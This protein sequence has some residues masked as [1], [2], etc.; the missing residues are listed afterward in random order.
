MFVTV[1]VTMRATKWLR[2]GIFWSCW[3]V[4]KASIAVGIRAT[5]RIPYGICKAGNRGV[6]RGLTR[7][8][9]RF[10]RGSK[11]CISGVSASARAGTHLS[12]VIRGVYV[13]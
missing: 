5:T 7:V 11:A 8:L 1:R 10:C 13:A 6:L 9:A 3:R 12:C 2:K 4:T